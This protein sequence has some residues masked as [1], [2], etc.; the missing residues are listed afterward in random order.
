MKIYA[1]TWSL[2]LL[3]FAEIA[4][5]QV[6]TSALNLDVAGRRYCAEIWQGQDQ[7]NR[8]AFNSCLT[9]QREGVLRVQSLR[10]V[11]GNQPFFRNQGDAVLPGR[12]IVR[13]SDQCGPATLL[14]KRR[15]AGL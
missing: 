8:N 1:C 6:Q 3:F 7:R 12:R 9:E 13:P 10:Q 4:L 2:Y 11:F 5:S 15:G 14:F